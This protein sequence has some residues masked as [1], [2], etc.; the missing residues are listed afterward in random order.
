MVEIQQV[1]M[2]MASE[3][4]KMK[5]FHQFDDLNYF[6]REKIQDVVQ[7]VDEIGRLCFFTYKNLKSF[8]RVKQT[9]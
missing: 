1:R 9:Q 8:Q 6:W 2:H 5:T 3:L 4:D 7:D